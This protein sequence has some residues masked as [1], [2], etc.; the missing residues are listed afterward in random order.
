MKHSASSSSGRP[1]APD[2]EMEAPRAEGGPDPS[3]SSQPTGGTSGAVRSGTWRGSLGAGWQT[4]D[5]IWAPDVRGGYASLLQHC[6]LCGELVRLQTAPT[7]PDS[8]VTAITGGSHC[9]SHWQVRR[10]NQARS[11]TG[12]QVMIVTSA[13]VTARTAAQ[14]LQDLADEQRLWPGCPWF[15]PRCL[16]CG[17]AWET[18]FI[19]ASD[20]ENIM[21]VHIYCRGCEVT[22]MGSIYQLGD[23]TVLSVLCRGAGVMP[24]VFLARPQ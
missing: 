7:P 16:R 18:T 12:A 3:A 13:A 11:N 10:A 8:M 2:V 6:P 15:R 19:A 17:T 1:P 9:D 4:D 5:G 23:R 24:F 22:G 20:M 21:P 14:D